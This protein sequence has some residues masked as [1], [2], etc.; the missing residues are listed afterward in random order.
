MK[1]QIKATIN[2]HL[3]RGAFYVLL[4]LAVCVIPCTLAQR[5][6]AES[7]PP[8]NSSPEAR[9]KGKDQLQGMEARAAQPTSAPVQA[10]G[11][12]GTSK[13]NT[14]RSGAAGSQPTTTSERGPLIN[15]PTPVPQAAPDR[16]TTS[17]SNTFR[18]LTG[19]PKPTSTPARASKR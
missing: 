10:S 4:L 1:K 18:T 8:P 11:S 13:S 16:F 6:T 17:K 5:T 14:F 19:S 12:I 3:T 15:R 9:K 7:S 2:A